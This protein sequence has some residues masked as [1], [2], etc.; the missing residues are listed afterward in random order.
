MKVWELG[1]GDELVRL[2]VQGQLSANQTEHSVEAA[3]RGVGFAYCL[4]RRITNEVAA[5]SLEIVVPELASVGPP[6]SS[7]YSSRR[8]PPSGLRQPLDMISQNENLPPLVKTQA[9]G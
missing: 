6:L 4:E 8:Q 3:L 2:D 1:D 7:Y 9:A 5:G